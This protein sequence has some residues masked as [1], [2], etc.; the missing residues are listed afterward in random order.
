MSKRFLAIA[1]VSLAVAVVIRAVV[2]R[3]DADRAKKEFRSDLHISPQAQPRT[4]K[5]RHFTA[6]SP[7]GRGVLQHPLDLASDS[8]GGV[9]VIDATDRSIKVFPANGSRPTFVGGA[10]I[11]R[12]PNS[13]AIDRGRIWVADLQGQKVVAF[14]YDNKVLARFSTETKPVRVVPTENGIITLALPIHEHLFERYSFGGV[15][16]SAFG[17]YLTD[18]TGANGIVL[19]GEIAASHG[20]II[21]AGFRVGIIS[22]FTED[23]TMRY[24]RTTVKA[25]PIPPTTSTRKGCQGVVAGSPIASVSVNVVGNQIYTTDGSI[26]DVYGLD[27]GNYESSFKL[28][29][30]CLALSQQPNLAYCLT[31]DKEVVRWKVTE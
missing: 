22:R 30:P 13:L 18:Q 19:D 2:S 20:G 8:D 26:V 4:W 12:D 28:P 17:K 27:D 14:S 31:N 7:I 29:Q 9:F 6:I 24:T 21:Y 25:V 5:D 10:S 1:L 3:G 11:L 15:F 23:G 16:E